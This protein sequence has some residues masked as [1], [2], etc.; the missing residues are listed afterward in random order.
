M[1]DRSETVGFFI[2]DD[3]M[4]FERTA[5]RILERVPLSGEFAEEELAG[6]PAGRSRDRGGAKGPTHHGDSLLAVGT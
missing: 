5:C 6:C 3:R 4:S 1:G 2:A